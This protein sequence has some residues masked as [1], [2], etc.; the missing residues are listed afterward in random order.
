M[1]GARHVRASAI[2]KRL[3]V[4]LHTCFDA[5]RHRLERSVGD[6]ALVVDVSERGDSTAS[7]LGGRFLVLRLWRILAALAG[8][9]SPPP[10]PP[11]ATNPNSIRLCAGGRSAEAGVGTG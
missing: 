6:V 9:T 7:F 11:G 2:R 3:T 4:P 8:P 10:P 5:A 1:R